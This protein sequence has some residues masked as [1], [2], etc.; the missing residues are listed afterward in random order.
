MSAKH[1]ALTA[2]QDLVGQQPFYGTVLDLGIADKNQVDLFAAIGSTRG[3]FQG[4]IGWPYLNGL[5]QDQ[6]QQLLTGQ[7]EQQWRAAGGT[8]GDDGKPTFVPQSAYAAQL[9]QGLAGEPGGFIW[10]DSQGTGWAVRLVPLAA[11][12]AYPGLAISWDG[13]GRVIDPLA[14]EEYQRAVEQKLAELDSGSEAAARQHLR[15][16]ADRMWLYRHAEQLLWAVH[17]AVLIQRSSLVLLPDVALGQVIWGSD[18]QSWPDNWRNTLMD[19]LSSLSAL[20]VAGLRIGGTQW[21]PRFTMRSV[22]V[23]HCEIVEQTRGKKDVCSP[24]CPLWNS[25]QPHEHF[26]IQIGYGF[27][28][29]LEHFA[30]TDD[31]QGGRQFDFQQKKPAGDAGKKIAEARRSGQIVP[32]HLPTK[33]FGQVP[34]AQAGIV[35]ALVREVTRAKGKSDRQDKAEV[36]VGNCVPD[37]RGRRQIVCPFLL[38]GG[39][40]VAF[41]GNGKRRGL[42]YLIVGKGSSGWLARCGYVTTVEEETKWTGKD[43]IGHVTRAFLD[44]LSEVASHLGLIAIGLAR[45]T[46]EWLDLK[47][48]KSIAEMPDGLNMLNEIH[49]RVYGPEDYLDRAR[50]LVAEKG[51]FVTIPGGGE[52]PAASVLLGDANLAMRV[53]LQQAGVSQDELARHLGVSKSFVSKLLNGKKAWPEGMRERA[54]AFLIGDDAAAVSAK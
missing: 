26:L 5:I 1:K 49:L 42:G 44:D 3:P 43:G 7:G 30:T 41:N 35:Q 51:R 18:R 32:V 36:L 11:Q 46:G 4:V 17:Q 15:Q 24:V 53:R 9:V 50:N 52:M 47:R 22:A 38:P 28:G 19:I 39:R 45:K 27:L 2:R 54:E 48:I 20:H 34:P 31:K 6:S 10:T 40:Y 8:Y 16:I 12:H 33:V 25:P 13:A 29:L 14:R 23:A 21:R 37:I